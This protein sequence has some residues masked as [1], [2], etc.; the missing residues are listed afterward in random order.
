MAL[1]TLA[2]R[3]QIGNDWRLPVDRPLLRRN[4]W[5]MQAVRKICFAWV[6][7]GPLWL[8][9]TAGAA[10]AEDELVTP[11]QPAE[12][13][14]YQYP[15]TA[16]ALK[17]DVPQTEFSS[18]LSGPDNGLIRSSSV[19]GRRIGPVVQFVDAAD[20][21]RQLMI[22]VTPRRAIPRSL[23]SLEVVQLE[24]G[25]HN[26]GAL[27]RAYRMLSVGAESADSN[28]PSTW[29][30]KAYSFRNAAQIFAGLGW[31]EMRLWSEYMA[32]H[33]VLHRLNDPLTTLELLEEING[34]ATR[35][36]LTTVQ[37]AALSLEVDALL[38]LAAASAE[39][40]A[41]TYYA[42]A[43]EA[44]FKAAMLAQRLGLNAE[45]ALALF[46]DA[47]AYESQGEPGRALESY[48][49]ALAVA[50]HSG[51]TD[52]INQIRTASASLHESMGSAAGAIEALEDTDMDPSATALDVVAVQQATRLFEKGRLLND[53]YRYS[54]AIPALSQALDLQQ[55]NRAS[56]FWKRTVLELAWS[57]Y[58]RGNMD[59]ALHL[60]ED[61]LN[62]T[63][64]PGAGD[65]AIRGYASIANIYRQRRQ[66]R[67]AAR[68]REM[69]D[70]RI[71]GGAGRAEFLLDS[72]ID[73]WARE[74]AGAGGLRP[75][76][77]SAMQ[78]AA[79]ER[80]ELVGQHASLYLCL[81]QSEQH[82]TT[83]CGHSY[84][85]AAHDALRRA[86]IPR[87]AADA[88]L[89]W[90]RILVLS[91]RTREAREM[92][93]QY[94]DELY[95]YLNALP[96]VLGAWYWE[97]R[98]VLAREYL[99]L[100]GSAAPS[101][102][103]GKISGRRLM[104]AME[105]IRMLEA[106]QYRRTTDQPLAAETGD[107][108]RSL[109]ARRE[110]ASGTEA[111]QLG[112]EVDRRLNAARRSAPARTE[113]TNAAQLDR[114]LAKLGRTEAVLSYTFSGPQARA[115]LAHQG[116]V[117]VFS[118][119]STERIASRLE[120]LAEAF[121]GPQTEALLRELDALGQMLLGPLTGALP[122]KVYLLPTGPLLGIALDALRV[123]GEYLAQRH[124]VATL[125]SLASIPRRIPLMPSDFSER[126]FL[127]GNPQQQSDPFS[128]EL[129]TSPEVGAVTDH[130]IGP[131]LHAV[132]GVALRR[133]EFA[134]PRFTGAALI[135]LALAGTVDLA[136][137]EAS[138]LLL[139]PPSGDRR[140]PNSYLA[141][142]DVRGFHLTA[143]MVLLSGTNL[144]NASRASS[145]T[146]LAFVDDFLDSGATAVVASLWHAGEI[147]NAA[148]AEHLYPRLK[149]DPDIAA[150]LHETKN[151]MIAMDPGRNL[152]SWAG[153]QL[154]IR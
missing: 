50:K 42:R 99:A 146:R 4:L 28:D 66:F 61:L 138:R 148:F 127:A 112:L 133:D 54:E 65:A 124:Q 11:E 22:E 64:L 46:K 25:D 17:I 39:T 131:G 48:E 60:L 82:D 141:P 40:S 68:F 1:R 53:T 103:G 96:G 87:L 70:Q 101:E 128:F 111:K 100:A 91:G 83:D 18:R 26:D 86:G 63:S 120:L 69:Q 76:I 78:A 154:F 113:L 55:D 33:L 149:S 8:F 29:A 12:F 115:L 145:A 36:G 142:V 151:A 38:M 144:I 137:P 105:Q 3:R 56:D 67:Q 24:P 119:P 139:A 75:L 57:E 7:A 14:I 122:E 132:Q 126:V 37:F 52:L 30:M 150:A 143:G 89:V 152:H 45:H 121:P 71:A 134:D 47:R 74:G 32:A 136:F 72:A 77:E 27:I 44:L 49:S 31:E 94:M 6:F 21:P 16:L 107:A 51:D 10:W 118:L 34:D 106:A 98:D 108:L 92:M 23:L 125:S 104:L 85:A 80:D 62:R 123:N 147:A 129:G 88:G 73:A 114:L 110:S 58:S 15:G 35:A 153:F 90:S 9:A 59:A 84:A 109:L 135:H 5:R 93:E 102:A 117:Q 95:W 79:R 116:Q 19:P 41:D 140:D 130:F 13:M 43:H 2:E 20:R 97:N 81:L